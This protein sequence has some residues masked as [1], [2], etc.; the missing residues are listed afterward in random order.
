MTSHGTDD[1]GVYRIFGLLPGEYVVGIESTTVAVPIDVADAYRTGMEGNDPARQAMSREMASIRGFPGGPRIDGM[2]LSNMSGSLMP[3]TVRG[4]LF[5]YPTTFYPAAAAAAQASV[6]TIGSGEERSAIDFQLKPVPTVRVSG[7]VTGPEGPVSHAAVR[8]IPAAS[9]V[10]STEI[11]TSNTMTDASGAF[12]FLGVTPG[13]YTLR[14]ARMPPAPPPMLAGTSTI[15]E[16]GSG[17][18]SMSIS[19]EPNAPPPPL[20]AG[21]TWWAN[22]PVSVGASDLADVAV[23]LRTGAR[24]TGRVEFEGAAAATLK[25]DVIQRVA[26]FLTSGSNER[27]VVGMLRGRVEG[28][29]RFSTASIPGGLYTLRAA[30][31]AGWTFKSAI[32]EGRDLADQPIDVTSDISGVVV[33]FTDTP[34]EL[35]GT[36]AADGRAIDATVL[37]FPTEPSAWTDWGV[38]SRRLRAIR[39]QPNGTFRMASLPEGDYY[40]IAVSDESA[41]DWQDQ[42]ALET[43]SRS[44]TT[45]RI[46]DGQKKSVQLRVTNVARRP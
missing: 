5:T 28:D 18:M 21:D 24:I 19:G 43:L 10:L 41:V 2:A 27:M 20:P 29:G 14:V 15:I 35:S 40:V 33:T 25:P 23:S 31:P 13:Q 42:K 32:H 6:I 7:L 9:E 22:V 12:R 8:L 4:R 16:T 36:I 37:L 3:T 46:E 1:R 44:A 34:S 17:R 11:E 38:S 39:P 30:G 45:I 26:I